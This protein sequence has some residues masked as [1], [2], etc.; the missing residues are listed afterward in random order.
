[1]AQFTPEQIAE[2]ERSIHVHVGVQ[3]VQFG[4]ILEEGRGQVEEART[5]LGTHNQELHASAD[6][7]TSLVENLNAKEAAL[8]QLTK[9]ILD[10]AMQQ[11][12]QALDVS[13]KAAAQSAG[14]ERLTCQIDEALTKIE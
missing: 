12:A 2:I 8:A 10:F 14:L 4:Q 6:R 1:M 13:A 3:A 7:V 5:L 9:G 11:D